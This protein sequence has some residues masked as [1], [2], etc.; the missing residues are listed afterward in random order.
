MLA[1]CPGSLLAPLF[2]DPKIVATLDS[3]HLTTVIA[4]HRFVASSGLSAS[5]RNEITQVDILS[6]VCSQ[7]PKFSPH[8]LRC[9]VCKVNK[10]LHEGPRCWT[11]SLLAFSPPP[12]LPSPLP[13]SLLHMCAYVFVYV[14]GWGPREQCFS[15][16]ASTC[17]AIC[18]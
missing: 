9:H 3:I 4:P 16:P 7:P 17:V 11:R 1:H 15:D 12:S 13:L 5:L 6:P 10:Y 14:R 8:S 2:C 18:G